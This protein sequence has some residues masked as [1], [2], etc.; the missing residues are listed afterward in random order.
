MLL[1]VVA[2]QSS[3]LLNLYPP[4]HHHLAMKAASRWD[5]VNVRQTTSTSV[6]F[7]SSR[8]L[9]STVYH[10]LLGNSFGY[11]VGVCLCAGLLIKSAFE[12]LLKGAL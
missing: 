10:I 9:V 5:V 11:R 1:V 6:G 12:N 8:R 3:P 2:V 7:I 4:H